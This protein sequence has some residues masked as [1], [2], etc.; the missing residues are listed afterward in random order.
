MSIIDN[1]KERI[2]VHAAYKR[3]FGTEDGKTILKHLM[4]EGFVFDTTFVAGDPHK[5]AMNEGSR[6]VIL[7]IM[8]FVAK[9]HRELVNQIEK[10]ISKNE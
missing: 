5:S 3:V 1:L 2:H 9:D 10:E 6:R 7:S 4:K 8:R